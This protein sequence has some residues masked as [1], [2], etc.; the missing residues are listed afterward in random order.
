MIVGAIVIDT[1]HRVIVKV[2]DL[3]GIGRVGCAFFA[4]WIGRLR[5]LRKNFLDEGVAFRFR[6]LSFFEMLLFIESFNSLDPGL[7]G[8]GKAR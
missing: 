4:F 3:W 7:L 5:A 1:F 6:C 2:G 8:G